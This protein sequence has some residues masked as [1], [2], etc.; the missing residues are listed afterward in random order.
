MGQVGHKCNKS[1]NNNILSCPT[2]I[3]SNGTPLAYITFLIIVKSVCTGI[4]PTFIQ[5]GSH[6]YRISFI[7]NYFMLT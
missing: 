5:T 6:V 4:C 1:S 7:N 3:I 2:S